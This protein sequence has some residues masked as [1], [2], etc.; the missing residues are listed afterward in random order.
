MMFESCSFIARTFSIINRPLPCLAPITMSVPHQN[1]WRESRSF[2]CFEGDQGQ[3]GWYRRSFWLSRWGMASK[4]ISP[5]RRP[6]KDKSSNI[7]IRQ[8]IGVSYEEFDFFVM[9]KVIRKWFCDEVIP[10]HEVKAPVGRIW[11]LIPWGNSERV[12]NSKEVWAKSVLRWF[13]QKQKATQLLRSCTRYL[14][15]VTISYLSV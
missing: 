14:F 11:R 3:R 1:I 15:F 2:S 9:S 12:R 6:L 8:L 4:N 13:L 5:W 10:L 7:R